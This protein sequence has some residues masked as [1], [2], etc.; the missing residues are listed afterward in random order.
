MKEIVNEYGG[1]FVGVTGMVLFLGTMSTI[2]LSKGGILMQM[3]QTW[4]NGGVS[5]I[6]A[7]IAILLLVILGGSTTDKN[8][9]IYAGAGEIVKEASLTTDGNAEFERYWRLR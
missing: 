2:L 1:M 8:I 4:M 5:V 3:I 6:V 7:V 9:G